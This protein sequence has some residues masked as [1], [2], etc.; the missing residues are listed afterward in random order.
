MAAAQDG[1]R[2]YKLAGRKLF[3]EVGLV[4]GVE[5]VIKR[6]VGRGDL[7]VNQIVHVHAG[8]G[9]NVFF[10]VQK[11]LDLV[12][13]LVRRLAGLRVES[14]AP[15]QIEGIADEYAVAERGLH[16]F[17]GKVDIFARSFRLRL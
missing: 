3:A 13:D 10:A 1:T 14:D 11:K 16:A 12:F 17:A 4:N 9:Q 8:L 7:H 5:L 15:G 2:P 6:Q